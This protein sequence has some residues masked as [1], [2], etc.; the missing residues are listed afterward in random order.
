MNFYIKKSA[1]LPVLLLKLIKDGKFDYRKFYEELSNTSITFSMIDSKTGYYKV[2]NA[3]AE[4]VLTDVNGDDFYKELMLKY[5]F[6]K[7]DT[8]TPGV[9]FGEFKINFYDTENNNA[10]T[11]ELIVPIKNQ[12]Y[13]HVLDS[14]TISDTNYIL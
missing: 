11:G 9:Y 8:D 5:K 12:L 14:S 1:T 13:I 2:A 3:E 7:D 10:E 4:V 6:T